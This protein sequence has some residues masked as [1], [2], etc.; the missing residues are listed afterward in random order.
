MRQIKIVLR[1]L[2]SVLIFASLL[3]IGPATAEEK[4]LQSIAPAG[5][6]ALFAQTLDWLDDDH[7]VARRCRHHRLGGW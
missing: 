3:T 5:S 2:W 4:P 7:K 1:L 6:T